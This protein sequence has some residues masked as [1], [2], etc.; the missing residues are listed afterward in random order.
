V[1]LVKGMG[2]ETISSPSLPFKRIIEVEEVCLQ[3]CFISSLS[4]LVVSS[5]FQVH[6]SR[7]RRKKIFL[8]KECVVERGGRSGASLLLSCCH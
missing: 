7:E 4:S 5:S 2:G 8:E 6:H 3:G 1:E